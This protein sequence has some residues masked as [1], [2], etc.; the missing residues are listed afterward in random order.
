[1]KYSNIEQNVTPLEMLPDLED[2]EKNDFSTVLP[3]G[4]SKYSF[5]S[6]TSSR[7]S[8]PKPSPPKPSPPKPPTP[9]PP[10][11]TPATPS[12]SPA[13]SKRKLRLS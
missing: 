13:R 7:P 4:D 8:P 12:P 5:C 10:T 2:L 11:P 9:K 1:M 3:P 6:T